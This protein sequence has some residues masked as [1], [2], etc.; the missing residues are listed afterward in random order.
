M[1]G[2][3]G[4]LNNKNVMA[5]L[6][7]GLVQLE[8]GGYDSVSIAAI[9]DGQIQW[10]QAKGLHSM[11][12]ELPSN[13]G[14]G[15]FGI[16]YAHWTE[17]NQSEKYHAHFYATERVAIVYNGLIDNLFELKEE[18]IALGYEFDGNTDSE[19]VLHVIN[20]YLDIGL[21]PKEAISVTI[22]RL[23]GSFAIIALFA[24]E[25]EQLIAARRGNPLTIGLAE[26]TFYVASDANTLKPLSCQTMQLED[27]CPA[28]LSSVLPHTIFHEEIGS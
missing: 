25:G 16:A 23:Q 24:G 19:V 18:L 26:D 11:L 9:V 8:E 6:L 4:L 2:I 13:D 7:Q 28:V 12:E 27:G 3:F 10:H 15:C 5:T 20:R 21:L 22:M 1:S 17:H 14:D